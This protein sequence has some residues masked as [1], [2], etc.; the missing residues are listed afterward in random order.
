M[1]ASRFRTL[2]TMSALA[3]SACSG[4][5]MSEEAPNLTGAWSGT[6]AAGALFGTLH[7]QSVAKEPVFA[8]LTKVWTLTI[9]KQEGSS[10][11]GTW[12]TETKKEPLVGVIRRDNV[13]LYFADDDNLFEARLLSANEMELCGLEAGA[14]TGGASMAACLLM[15]RK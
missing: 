9:E 1:F 5:A 11:I 7:H 14:S 2:L 8:N 10:L 13:T 15:K 4:V 3:L 12:S 6:T